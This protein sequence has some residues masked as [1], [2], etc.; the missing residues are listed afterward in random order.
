MP[1]NR[2][3]PVPSQAPLDPLRPRLIIR[4]M[5]LTAIGTALRKYSLTPRPLLF[6]ICSMSGATS[7]PP[8]TDKLTP[9]GRLL[10][11]VRKL[12]DYG[13]QVGAA[14]TQ[15]TADL[16]SVTRDFGT[17]DI[18]LILG[19]I[20]CG[21][22]RA[23]LLEARIIQEAASLDAAPVAPERSTAVTPRAPPAAPRP[24]APPKLQ[25]DPRLAR[26]PTSEEIAEEVRHRPIGA[27]LAD[28][29]RDL[30][31]VPSHPLWLELMVLVPEHGGN[32][33]ALFEDIW[34]RVLPLPG[35]GPPGASP[36]SLAPAATG[37]P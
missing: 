25:P 9:S 22:E 4:Q 26:L 23:N 2:P 1:N 21:L 8:P 35:I 18:A 20:R 30:G 11:L 32:F 13:K 7:S 16:A 6:Y 28:I 36:P 31:I 10:S 3:C 5:C 27:V 34:D 14:L 24:P 12:I 17:K 19:R 15:C 33:P 29:C 37:P